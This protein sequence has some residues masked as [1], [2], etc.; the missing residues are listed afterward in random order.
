MTNEVEREILNEEEIAL[1]LN[2]TFPSKR[3][4]EARDIFVFSCYTGYAYSEVNALT[5]DHLGIGLDG[6]KWIFTKRTKTDNRSNVLL[7]PI[8]LHL[9]E[10]YKSH[11]VCIR[12]SKLFPVKSNQKYNDYLKEIGA[13]CGIKKELTTHIARHTFATTV[14]LSN[15]VP[16]ES[17]SSML[18]HKSM[19]TTQVY[20]KIVQ[21]KLS[22]DMKSLREKLESKIQLT[23]S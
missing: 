2:K 19:R 8:A 1:L 17:V 5:P 7:L 6:E 21:K 22:N 20:A 23:G 3:L 9:I 18:G 16:I 11:P 13:Q 14:T 15:G 10:K 4:D 12:N